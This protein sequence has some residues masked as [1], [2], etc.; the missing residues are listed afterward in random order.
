MF[1]NLPNLLQNY[2]HIRCMWKKKILIALKHLWPKD[3]SAGNRHGAS[4]YRIWPQ[5]LLQVCN[6]MQWV[7]RYTQWMHQVASTQQMCMSNGRGLEHNLP[8]IWSQEFFILEQLLLLNYR[9]WLNKTFSV[10]K[11]TFWSVMLANVLVKFYDT[12]YKYFF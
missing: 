9:S 6:R 5:Q 2:V 8:W 11:S 1:W 4:T 12:K 7:N 10:L 3:L